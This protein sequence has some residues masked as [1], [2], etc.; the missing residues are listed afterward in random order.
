MGFHRIDELMEPL[1][2][3]PDRSDAWLAVARAGSEA[4]E[5]GQVP[6]H[7]AERGR[8]LRRGAV[9]LH[10]INGVPLPGFKH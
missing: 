3:L 4:T 7:L 5:L 9:M 10:S 6:H 2:A 8:S 1:V